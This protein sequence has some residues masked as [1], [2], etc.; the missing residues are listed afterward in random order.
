EG[1]LARRRPGVA[2]GAQRWGWLGRLGERA[3]A[4]AGETCAAA[5]RGDDDE[6]L[7]EHA[8]RCQPRN[9]RPGVEG[10]GD[11][12]QIELAG[13]ERLDELARALLH[14][15]ELDAGVVAMEAADQIGRA[16]V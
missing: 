5:G 16:N 2:G 1:A 15:H 12:R 7:A 13:P 14:E 4:P 9:L 8:A 6:V 3:P 11:Q 10:A